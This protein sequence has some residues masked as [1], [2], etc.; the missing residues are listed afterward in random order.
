MTG[1]I[2]NLSG[3]PRWFVV[4]CKR[5]EEKLAHWNL[6]AQGFEVYLPMYWFMDRKT[7]GKTGK[8]LF[9]GYV[10]VK[11]N[12]AV[13]PW[14]CICSTYGVKSLLCS[15]N[16]KPIAAADGHIASIQAREDEDGM[17]N[18][19]EAK[20]AR[21]LPQ[22]GQAVRFEIKGNELDG[23]FEERVDD[24][25]CTILIKFLGANRGVRVHSDRLLPSSAVA[26]QA[27]PSN[28][29]TFTP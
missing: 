28:L 24:R 18:L 1:H 10:F 27:N 15:A 25:R 26:V 20:P 14:R 23:I 7:Q 13:D 4:Q 29:K 5:K 17:I 12:P 21:P 3:G 2:P 9:P 22:P 16:G 19:V 8:P 11:I 6:K